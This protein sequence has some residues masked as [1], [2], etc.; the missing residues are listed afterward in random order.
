MIRNNGNWLGIN[1]MLIQVAA[2]ISISSWLD[3]FSLF[4]PSLGSLLLTIKLQKP[5]RLSL[6]D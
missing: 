2:V 5:N 6:T 4:E 1:E 3:S